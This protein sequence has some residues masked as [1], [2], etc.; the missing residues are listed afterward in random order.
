VPLDDVAGLLARW[1]SADSV[2]SRGRV[3]SE[4]AGQVAQLSGEERQLLAMAVAEQGAPRLAD[5]LSTTAGGRLDP[6]LA[7][8]LAG[9]LL[10]FD[11]ARIDHLASSLHH[12]DHLRSRLH[13]AL[14]HLPPPSGPPTDVAGA[15]TGGTLPA[16]SP[17]PPAVEVA[18]LSEDL[19][20]TWH[21]AD[22]ELPHEDDLA[23]DEPVHADGVEATDDPAPGL[24]A[25]SFTE[26]VDELRR[27]SSATDRRRMLA[28]LEGRALSTEQ[29]RAL[30]DATP[31]GW[32]RRR[33]AR[34]LVDLGV[35][36]DAPP[37]V[38]IERL[39]RASDRVFI[40]G[41]LV[42]TGRLRPGELDRLLPPGAAR[43]LA[44]RALR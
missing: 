9:E 31:D 6:E 27:S 42:D 35:L 38:V 5:R 26:L 21:V 1:R 12:P 4:I 19:P 8:N 22:T 29:T 18:P 3:A 16:P 41:A 36:G 40:A 34:Q 28:E 23:E 30:L 7:T 39:S 17:A 24:T 33:V 20:E 10:A 43:R 37:R 32:K 11:G 2:W 13:E 25:A 15:P 14:D 44:A